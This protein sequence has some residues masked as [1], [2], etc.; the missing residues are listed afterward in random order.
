MKQSDFYFLAAYIYI[1]PHVSNYVA[2]GLSA[3]FLIAAVFS[4]WGE[5][6]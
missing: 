5:R 3:M 4:L 1:A 2:L 6:K